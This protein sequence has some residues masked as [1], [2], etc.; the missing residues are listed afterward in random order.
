VLS[1]ATVASQPPCIRSA[2]RAAWNSSSRSVFLPRQADP[3]DEVDHYLDLR[4]FG[5]PSRRVNDP[6]AREP[7][8]LKLGL[9]LLS[10]VAFFSQLLNESFGCPPSREVRDDAGSATRRCPTSVRIPRRRSSQQQ[11][12]LRRAESEQVGDGHN[13]GKMAE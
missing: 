12:G 2:S 5:A 9:I 11:S 6:V 8:S 7:D 10:D 1:V 4:T 3:R 13:G